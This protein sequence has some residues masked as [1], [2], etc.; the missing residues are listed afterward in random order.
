[1]TVA[2]IMNKDDCLFRGLA[3]RIS[4]S[5]FVHMRNFDIEPLTLCDM[6]A[7]PI[8]CPKNKKTGAPFRKT[9][10]RLCARRKMTTFNI[11][12]DPL[13]VNGE[14]LWSVSHLEPI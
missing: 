11:I 14:K 8:N 4:D 13:C 2:E 9:S 1:M 6:L 12:L 7:A 3:L 10:T 5:A